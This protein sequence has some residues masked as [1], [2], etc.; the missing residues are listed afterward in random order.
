MSDSIFFY[1]YIYTHTCV[2]SYHVE[3]FS[4][5]LYTKYVKENNCVICYQL[6]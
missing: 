3:F 6:L 4:R 5:V 2:Y 1:V